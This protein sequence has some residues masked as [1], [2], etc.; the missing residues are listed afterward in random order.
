[1]TI[2]SQQQLAPGQLFTRRYG[3]RVGIVGGSMGAYNVIQTA[4]TLDYD[5]RGIL[6]AANMRM[7]SP[8]RLINYAVAGATS[9]QVVANQLPSL[10]Q[11]AYEYVAVFTGGNDLLG[12]VPVA[13]T[14]A[15]IQTIVQKILS[16]GAI[17]ILFTIP[18]Y[19]NSVLTDAQRSAQTQLN[20]LILTYPY[21]YRNVLA[22][23][24]FAEYINPTST[25]NAYKTNYTYDNIHPSWRGNHAA[26]INLATW[27]QAS[28]GI[29]PR[30]LSVTSV[31]DTWTVCGATYA[32]GVNLCDPGVSFVQGTSGTTG[33]LNAT[34]CAFSGSAPGNSATDRLNIFA[35]SLGTAGMQCAISTGTASDGV[36]YVDF[37]V[38]TTAAG[39]YIAVVA[40]SLLSRAT[41]GKWYESEV[42]AQIIG[43]SVR[44]TE[45][46]LINSFDSTQAKRS[47]IG[48]AQ[49]GTQPQGVMT[50][51]TLTLI[52]PRKQFFAAQHNSL[53]P[54]LRVKFVN[55]GTCTIRMRQM[56]LIG[57]D[58]ETG[59]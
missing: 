48:F 55:N 36:P 58:T 8:M 50:D 12:G 42:S 18:P 24:L 3:T 23:D 19:S 57:Y 4:D 25:T 59:N 30:T 13:T 10:Q 6:V 1:M 35:D 39:Q 17:P 38:T 56:G 22:F 52:T 15:N 29:Q 40:Q 7:G 5:N 27:L 51:A 31:V 9:A 11:G 14:F 32:S 44:P 54:I 47:S 34:T 49:A 2:R 43:G 26:S 46:C 37:A 21:V 41:E 28:A 16:V 53:Q 45:V 33:N 20:Q